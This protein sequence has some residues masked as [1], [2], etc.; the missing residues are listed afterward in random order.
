M[1][2]SKTQLFLKNDDILTTLTTI[3]SRV[4]EKDEIMKKSNFQFLFLC[5]IFANPKF[6]IT[7]VS[8]FGNFKIAQKSSEKK[9]FVHEKT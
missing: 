2:P 9:Y 1:V 7:I 4:F 6:L 8:F 5:N 3:L